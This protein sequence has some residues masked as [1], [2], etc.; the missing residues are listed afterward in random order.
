MTITLTPVTA[1]V[2]VPVAP[3]RAFDLYVHRPGRTHPDEGLSGAAAEIVYEPFE[4]GRWF[5]RGPDGGEHDWGRVLTYDPGQRLVLAWMVGAV[6]GEWVYDPDPA[7]ASRAEVTFQAVDGGTRVS[8]V[9][10]GFEAHGDGAASI[11]RGV[12]GGW[13]RDLDDLSRA[14]TEGTGVQT[15]HISLFCSDVEQCLDFY[16]SVGFR[17]AFRVPESGA[18]DHVEVDVAGARLG[19]VSRRAAGAQTGLDLGPESASAPRGPSAE[20]VLWCSDVDGLH[21]RA[22]ASGATE[23]VAPRATADGRRR[24][25]WWADPEGHVV[26]LVQAS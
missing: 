23:V 20:V 14:A 25:S 12:S 19:L 3:H 24:T 10:T 11:H 18:I 13:G 17:E 22:L 2:V 7:R 6:E 5:E 9:H 16:R 4:G 21:A 15:M 26:H 1:E 8:V